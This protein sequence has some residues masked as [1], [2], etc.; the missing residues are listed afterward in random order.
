MRLIANAAAAALL[1]GSCG[2]KALALP[3]DPIDRAASCGV[4]AAI[5][6]RAA[7]PDIKAPLPL[8]AQ[9]RILHYALLAGAEGESFSADTASTVSK[10]M[11]DLQASITEG[12][13]QDLKQ[14]CAKAYPAAELAEP[15]MPEG[16]LDAQLGCDELADFLTTALQRQEAE[17]GKELAEVRDLSRKLNSVLGPG[18]AARAGSGLE[19][20]REERRKALSAIAKSGPP[21]KVLRQCIERYG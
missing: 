15:Q 6:G 1:L 12:R 16:R 10:R 8:E 21:M 2:P 11:S 18:L 7:T 3:E 4:V 19:K 17:Y 20:Q 5:E 9:G 13:W 14:P